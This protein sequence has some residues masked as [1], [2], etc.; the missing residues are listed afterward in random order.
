MA[1]DTTSPKPD[2][3]DDIRDIIEKAPWTGRNGRSNELL[4]GRPE[5]GFS[6]VL[7]QCLLIYWRKIWF[8]LPAALV[9]GTGG[10]FVWRFIEEVLI[11]RVGPYATAASLFYT[12][13]GVPIGY[14]IEV[15][16]I[17][18]MGLAAISVAKTGRLEVIAS[19]LGGVRKIP[20]ILVVCLMPGLMTLVGYVAL[21]IPGLILS[22]M[23]YVVVPVMLVEKR[24]VSAIG[25]S[26]FLTQYY[27]GP[28]FG[29]SLLLGLL[30]SGF[31]YLLTWLGDTFYFHQ[32]EFS[33]GSDPYDLF[34]RAAQVI[35]YALFAPPVIISHS[36]VY[37][38]LVEI[39]EGGESENLRKIFE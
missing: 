16:Y 35:A 17:A 11:G 33:G 7:S 32:F 21:V 25:R 31:G 20:A 28:I 10:E 4:S 24:G 19:V 3:P 26:R 6:D 18:L 15:V 1:S 36:L 30:A 39:K 22:M 23:F 38:R 37:L 34:Y 27:R 8:F 13:A 9:V 5:F 29:I 2:S 14:L 12:F